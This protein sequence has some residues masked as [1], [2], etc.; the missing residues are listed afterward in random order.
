MKKFLIILTSLCLATLAFWELQHF[1]PWESTP[2][3]TST[4]QVGQIDHS[5]LPETTQIEFE[6]TT[7]AD[8]FFNE[9]IIGSS[10]FPIAS[11][12]PQIA[13]L[14]IAS[15]INDY[16]ETQYSDS[17]KKA[18]LP[19]L[20]EEDLTSLQEAI[21]HDNTL[22]NLSINIDQVSMTLG[23]ETVHIPRLIVQSPYQVANQEVPDNDVQLLTLAMTHLGNRLT[24]IC[25][26][27]QENNELLVYHL[28]NWTNP[29]F[30][31]SQQ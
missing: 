13:H 16:Y 31:Y 21:T 29:L 11:V 17:E 14:D 26:Y 3:T 12:P 27:N 9:M 19:P 18:N 30:T 24:M 1:I 20:S 7:L 2:T 10:Q 4:V 6:E 23:G 8:S 22:S 28:T 5:T 25:Y 15:A